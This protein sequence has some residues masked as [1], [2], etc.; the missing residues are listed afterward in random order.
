MQSLEVG[1]R[2]RGA[3]EAFVPLKEKAKGGEPN[4]YFA[5]WCRLK[6]RPQ[7]AGSSGAGGPAAAGAAAGGPGPGARGSLSSHLPSPPGM[8]FSKQ[9]VLLFSLIR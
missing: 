8:P 2:L 6:D 1:K 9:M 5:W 4:Y 7:A 3:T